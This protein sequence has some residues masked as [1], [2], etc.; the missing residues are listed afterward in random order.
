MIDMIE[1]AIRC[2]YHL[3]RDGKEWLLREGTRLVKLRSPGRRSFGFSLDRKPRP[4]GFFSDDPPKGLAKVCDGM[5]AVLH[6]S[7]LYLFAVEIKSGHRGDS[8]EQLVNGGLFW[9][10]LADLCIQHGHLRSATEV[11]HVGLLMW[12]PRERA[13]RKGTTVH[14]GGDDWRALNID[15]FNTGYEVKNRDD[16]AL[17]AVIDKVQEGLKR[18]T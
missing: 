14:F 15:G 3:E 6:E 11:Y 13:P 9:R 12:S 5:V 17:T 8:R 18:S 1:K 7:K 10:W 2:P 4:L 16:I